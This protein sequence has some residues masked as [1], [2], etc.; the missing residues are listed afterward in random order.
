MIVVKINL[1]VFP[2]KQLEF[3]QTLLSMIES[4]RLEEGCL[5]FKVLNDTMDEYHFNLL[6]EWETRKDM[7]NHIR[8]NLFGVLLGS[9]ILLGQSI[10]IKIL[11]VSA[12]EGI[13]LVNFVKKTGHD[14][15]TGN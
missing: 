5:S 15:M 9:R 6:E 10:K 3:K 11:T 1:K 14:I 7:N 8:S 4:I 12:K 2:E 13:E